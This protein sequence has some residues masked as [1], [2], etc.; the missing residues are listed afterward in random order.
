M[1]IQHILSINK[2]NFDNI[3]FIP[4]R[5]K[6]QQRVATA[7]AAGGSESQ[8]R[9]VFDWYSGSYP[10]AALHRTI[11]RSVSV[12]LCGQIGRDSVSGE[13]TQL[14]AKIETNSV[15]ADFIPL[16]FH[17][18]CAMN[19]EIHHRERRNALIFMF[20]EYFALVVMLGFIFR[21]AV[22]CPGF[23]RKDAKVLMK[24]KSFF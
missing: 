12:I 9:K 8:K 16:I 4:L 2:L 24:T 19:G 10:A 5:G 1:Y 6:V 11:P 20:R 13:L 23:G 15:S 17:P 7:A 21:C 14:T 18:L 22:G 3:L